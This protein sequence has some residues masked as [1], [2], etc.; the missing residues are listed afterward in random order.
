MVQQS[1]ARF[2]LQNEALQLNYDQFAHLRDQSCHVDEPVIFLY[3][4][5]S[6]R[7]RVAVNMA[8]GVPPEIAKYNSGH[9]GP[10]GPVKFR[11]YW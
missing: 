1:M 11:Y 9:F 10:C 2:V 8:W 6:H 4:S 3:A 5:R 7:A